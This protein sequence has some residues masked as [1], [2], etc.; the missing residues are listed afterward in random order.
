[1]PSVCLLLLVFLVLPIARPLSAGDAPNV[2]IIVADDLG[3]ADL[4]CTGATD[5]RTPNLDRLAATGVR[6]D[7]FRVCPMC[8]PTR[9]GLL[10]GRWPGRFGMMR[11]VVTPWSPIGLPAEEATLPERLSG[12]YP[13]RGIVGK[14][15]LGS[16]RRAY[17]PLA[18]GF[19]SFLGCYTGAVDYFTQ[20]RDGQRD[21]HIDHQSGGA[22]GYTTDLIADAAERFVGE[23]PVGEPWFLY[24]PFTAPHSP[25]Q[26][27]ADTKRRYAH[28]PTEKERTYAAMV[29]HMDQAV[30]RILRAV[31]SRAD[32]ANTLVWFFSDNGGVAGVGSNAPWRGH[33]L[34]VYEGGTRVCAALRWPAGGLRDGKTFAGRIGYIDVMPSVLAAA[35][36][37]IPVGGDGLDVL[38]AVRG[39]RVLPERP[40]FTY[41]HQDRTASASVHLGTWKLIV[42]GEIFGDQAPNRSEL[43]DLATDPGE[44]VD[45]ADAE[46]QRV[47]DL[48]AHLRTFSTWLKPGVGAYAEGKD[49]FVVPERWEMGD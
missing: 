10:T 25:F 17:H 9:A 24:V 49:G 43:Y 30:G 27:P 34:S 45:R 14:W 5:I 20:D 19:S 36:V 47:R 39:E 40:W 3:Y 12:R 15:H 33:K 26:A 28:L 6:L 35:G 21:W 13:R 7:D 31:E 2:L 11:A 18:H 42:R 22:T 23:S 8:S 37:E 41:L 48:H 44:R 38:P 16:A 29:D 46:L 32:A 4:G 1:M